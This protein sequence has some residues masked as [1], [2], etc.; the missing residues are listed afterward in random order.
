MGLDGVEFVMAVEE[1]FGL[2]I[3]DEDAQD[4]ITPGHFV[5][6]LEHRLATGQGVCLEQRAFH[7]LRRAGIA[8]LGCSRSAFRPKTRW[9][10][11]LP[12][13]KRRRMWQ[14]IHHAIGIVPWPEMPLWR[15]V[16]PHRTLD[17]TARFMA[18]HSAAALQPLGAEWSRLQIESTIRGLMAQ[19]LGITEFEWHHR[20]VDELRVD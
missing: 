9:E 16:P 12:A 11:V 14:L 2:A 4:L 18:T 8:V 20:F 13:K 19:Q 3:P 5:N 6:Y 7:I 1:A 10:D 15:R 17:E